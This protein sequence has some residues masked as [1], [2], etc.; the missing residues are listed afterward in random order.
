[1]ISQNTKYKKVADRMWLPTARAPGRGRQAG[2]RTAPAP[3][4]HARPLL[5]PGN[6][7]ILFCLCS[8]NAQRPDRAGSQGSCSRCQESASVGV[9]AE[10]GRGLEPPQAPGRPPGRGRK[11]AVP[12]RSA[13]ASAPPPPPPAKAAAHGGTPPGAHSGTGAAALPVT[14]TYLGEHAQEEDSHLEAQSTSA[15]SPPEQQPREQRRPPAHTPGPLH[16]RQGTT[17]APSDPELE[18]WGPQQSAP[19]GHQGGKGRGTQRPPTSCAKLTATLPSALR[20]VTTGAQH[21]PRLSVPTEHELSLHRARGTP[22][23][24]GRPT[25]TPGGSLRHVHPAS[26]QSDD[27]H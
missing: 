13:S 15:S 22:A 24:A 20:S 25:D 16:A 4:P 14:G 6:Q 27:A 21:C 1:M 11:T 19:Q 26:F 18:G 5:R 2:R 10:Q 23:S 3:P 7:F 17:P 12:A 9:E 8:L